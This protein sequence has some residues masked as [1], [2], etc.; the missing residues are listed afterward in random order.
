M[1]KVVCCLPT[2]FYT[3]K[4]KQDT[5]QK[6]SSRSSAGCIKDKNGNS[7]FVEEEIAQRWVE[8]VTEVYDDVREPIPPFQ[9][10]T[11]QK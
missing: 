10:L 7:L 8:Y 4:V 6:T 1:V 9:V 5:G 2:P 3:K 11:R